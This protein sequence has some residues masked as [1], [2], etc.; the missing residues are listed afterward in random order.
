MSLG[1]NDMREILGVI[2][3]RVNELQANC[4]PSSGLS[5]PI[6]D[7]EEKKRAFYLGKV[8]GYNLAKAVLVNVQPKKEVRLVNA[9]VVVVENYSYVAY[10][11]T[12]RLLNNILTET[13]GKANAHNEVQSKRLMGQSIAIR[14]IVNTIEHLFWG[15]ST[16]LMA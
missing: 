14:D 15:L 2:A 3:T 9:K 10:L 7:Y 11:R 8:H 6:S 12:I 13:K 1:G 4:V 5:I 16:N